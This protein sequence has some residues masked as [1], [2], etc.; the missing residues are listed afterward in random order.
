MKKKQPHIIIFNPDQMRADSLHH[1]GNEASHTPNMD[2]LINDGVSFRNAF[3]QN[4]VCTP[5]RCS[6]MSGWYPHVHG[7]RT[8]SYM[9]HKEEP[10]LLKELKDEGYHVWTNGRNDLIPAQGKKPF[11]DYANEVFNPKKVFMKMGKESRGEVGSDNFYSHYRGIIETPEGMDDVYD[12]DSAWVDGAV[13]FIKRRPKDKPI[14]VFLPLK[15]PHTPY[16]V[17]KKYYD[18]IDESKIPERIPAL[19]DWSDKPSILKGLVKLQG[20]QNWSEERWTKLRRT[21]L[22]MCSRV[23][24]QFGKVVDALKE[25]GIYDDSAVFVFSDHGDFTGD[26]GIVEKNQNTFEDCLT[27]VPF[28]IKPPK[29]MKVTPGVSDALVELVDFYATVEDITGLKQTHTH[30]GKSLRKVISGEDLEHR[31]EVYCEGGRL[32][33]EIHCNESFHYPSL[34]DREN[35]YFPRIS[36]QTSQGPEHTKATMIRT[37]DFK[38]VKRLDEKD[39]LYDLRNDLENVNN[40]IDSPNHKNIVLELKD[41]M[42]TWL[43]ATADVVPYDADERMTKDMLLAYVKA[44]LPRKKYLMVKVALMSG[45]SVSKMME[46][47]RKK[48]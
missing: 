43:Q 7:H 27:N 20:M 34:I 17:S 47:A 44:M 31:S 4:P 1:L 42:L 19:D 15:Y 35:E 28:I 8:I 29:E 25:E 10:V 22:A 23:D 14:C 32:K 5:S 33:E 38:Y 11:K 18:L 9:M 37:K 46:L 16:Q 3:C 30:F 39:E 36:L 45:V 40:L 24:D 13:D 21:Y 41:K 26:Y 2:K 12:V 6:F 48:S